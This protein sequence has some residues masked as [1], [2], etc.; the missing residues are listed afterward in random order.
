MPLESAETRPRSNF[1][2]SRVALARFS[3]V[4]SAKLNTDETILMAGTEYFGETSVQPRDHIPVNT[5]RNSH[6]HT[7]SRH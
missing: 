1:P 7:L 3:K 6:N 2:E 5:M 4:Q